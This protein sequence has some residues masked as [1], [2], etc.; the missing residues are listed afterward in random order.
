MTWGFWSILIAGLLPYVATVAAKWG[1]K[2]YDNHNPRAWLANQTGFR[3]R[4]NSAQENSFE[5]FPLFAAGVLVASYV[6]A[7]Q[8]LIDVFATIFIISR[9]L[10]ILCYFIDKDKL[11]STFWLVGFLSA[12]GLFVISA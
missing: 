3:A 12:I 5:A 1:A 8:N 10:Y 9:A 2:N 11:R 6:N 7:S 4:G